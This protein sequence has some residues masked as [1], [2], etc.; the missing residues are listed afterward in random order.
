[1]QQNW[2]LKCCKPDCSSGC[3]LLKLRLWLLGCGL[4]LL[5]FIISLRSWLALYQYSVCVG[6]SK[7]PK[8]YQQRNC[9]LSCCAIKK[10][11][12]QCPCLC[13]RLLHQFP[14]PAHHLKSAHC[15]T[16]AQEEKSIQLFATRSSWLSPFC[17]L[18]ERAFS[19][20]LT[21]ADTACL[22]SAIQFME[23]ACYLISLF[24]TPNIFISASRTSV[25]I[26]LNLQKPVGD[27]QGWVPNSALIQFYTKSLGATFDIS[28]YLGLAV[29]IILAHTV[30]VCQKLHIIVG[31]Q[32]ANHI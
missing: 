21:V 4:H 11:K 13:C 28:S 7:D 12:K 17:F 8:I 15:V 16:S 27:M 18:S 20:F 9:F 5:S 32:N 29:P 22:I 26:T 30:S 2:R 24:K 6:A 1:M 31:A 14:P 3:Y 10:Y 25:I 19:R 23:R